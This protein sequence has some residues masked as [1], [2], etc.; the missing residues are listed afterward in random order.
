MD[1]SIAIFCTV[2][3]LVLIV[4]FI[5]A[6][7]DINRMRSGQKEIIILL[8]KINTNLENNVPNPAK[9]VEKAPPV[10]IDPAT[11][12]LGRKK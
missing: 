11:L 1:E 3:G 9:S 10:P 4:L 2:M 7:W 8:A 12:N 6:V 5:L